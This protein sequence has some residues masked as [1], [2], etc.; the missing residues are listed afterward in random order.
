MPCDSAAF[1]ERVVRVVHEA[2]GWIAT[3]ELSDNQGPR[4]DIWAQY[5]KRYYSIAEMHE[6]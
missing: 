5:R 3:G 2:R 6:R 4:G 1:R